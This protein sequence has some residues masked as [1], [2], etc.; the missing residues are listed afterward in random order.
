MGIARMFY[1]TYYAHVI[2]V[3]SKSPFYHIYVT[4]SHKITHSTKAD[5]LTHMFYLDTTPF[6]INQLTAVGFYMQIPILMI[7]AHIGK[8]GL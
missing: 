7:M 3:L 4:V 6:H 5:M 1:V 2:S 8:R